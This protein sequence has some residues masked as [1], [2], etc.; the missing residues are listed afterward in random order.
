MNTYTTFDDKQHFQP[1]FDRAK[2]DSLHGWELGWEMLE[3][4]NV[5]SD[6]GEAEV[7]LSC[8]FSPGQKTLYFFWYLDAQVT[9]GGFIQFY[10]NGYRQYL[11]AI[12]TGLELI[13]DT[14]MIR[15]V[16]D[17]DKAYRAHKSDFDNVSTQQDV[18]NLFEKHESTFDKLDGEYYLA[19]DKT[20]SLIEAYMRTNPEQFVRLV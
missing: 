9:N 15:I 18:E 4:I 16:N 1:D 7:E 19:H 12:L 2:F 11:D 3:P 20:M 6:Q 5:A 10:L 8:R 13:G 17:A 14:E